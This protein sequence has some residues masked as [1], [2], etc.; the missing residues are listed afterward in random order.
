MSGY[1]V[2]LMCKAKLIYVE[3]DPSHYKTH[4][5]YHHG[6]Y[7]NHN[8]LLALN[9]LDKTFFQ[10]LYDEF[11]KEGHKPE[12]TGVEMD[13]DEAGEG[14]DS[15]EQT[16]RGVSLELNESATGGER[17][18]SSAE[19]SVHQESHDFDRPDET[20][21]TLNNE[22]HI[23]E[24]DK[25]RKQ[26]S[27][28]TSQKKTKIESLV[29]KNSGRKSETSQVKENSQSLMFPCDEC[30]FSFDKNIKLRKHKE[31]HRTGPERKYFQKE[32]KSKILSRGK[33]GLKVPRAGV[34]YEKPITVLTCDQCDYTTDKNIKLKKHKK[35]H[36]YNSTKSSDA[37]IISNSET[38][39]LK[40]E[41]KIA[42]K[43]PKKLYLEVKSTSKLIKGGGTEEQENVNQE[44]CV[45][46]AAKTFQQITE[47]S[48]YF[49]LFPKQLRRGSES[50]KV[51]FINLAP[52]FPP[53]W[54][55]RASGRRS[56]DKEYISP[57][58]TIFRSRKAAVEYLKCME[59]YSESE[60]ERVET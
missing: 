20:S 26:A 9:L 57:D 8:V 56:C 52:N 21:T 1:I 19:L 4:L 25:K 39:E 23:E 40:T 5:K 53:G 41:E 50:D 34:S 42:D 60:I 54:F 24:A 17:F 30:N 31:K 38:T 32:D 46:A 22:E 6:A 58:L 35:E 29:V 12:L 51:K 2:C 44:G 13:C 16:K 36:K 28:E 37:P 55:V 10:T 47:T 49:L 27:V 18:S 33:E 59:C 7:Y 3:E 14:N 11:V 43:S 48:E 45:P 15:D